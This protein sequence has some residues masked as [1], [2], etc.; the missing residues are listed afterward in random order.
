MGISNNQ[1]ISVLLTYLLPSQ[2][3]RFCLSKMHYRSL[4]FRHRVIL[5][6]ELSKCVIVIPKLSLCLEFAH[7]MFRWLYIY[8]N[9]PYS[10]VSLDRKDH[11]YVYLETQYNVDAHNTHAHSPL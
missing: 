2:R 5:V 6:H 3:C 11:Q 7:N 8:A 9:N 10:F 4:N 1:Q